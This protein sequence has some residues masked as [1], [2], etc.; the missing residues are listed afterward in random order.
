[1]QRRN[2]TV[3]ISV[4]ILCLAIVSTLVIYLRLGR[5]SPGE[6]RSKLQ[7]GWA[8]ESFAYITS[9]QLVLMDGNRTIA[10]VARFF[11]MFNS[12]EDKVV[13]TN[14]GSYVAFLEDVTAID[15]NPAT[16]KLITVNAHTGAVRRLSCPRCYD[17][18]PVGNNSVL[19]AAAARDSGNNPVFTEFDLSSGGTATHLKFGGIT[20]NGA[21][22]GQFLASTQNLVLFSHGGYADGVYAQYLTLINLDNHAHSNLGYF[23]SNGYELE[24]TS[25]ISG[26]SPSFAVAFRPNPGECVADFPI[27]VFRPMGS[28]RRT[29]MSNAEPPSGTQSVNEGLQV[30]DLWWG[31]D[32]HF[33]ATIESWRCDNSKRSESDKEIPVNAS[34]PWRL[35]GNSWVRN[36][37]QHATMVRQLPGN[38]SITLVIPDCIGPSARRDTIRYCDTGKLYREQRGKAT[39]IANGVI[40]LSS[41]SPR[42][43]PS[44]VPTLGQLAGDFASGKGFGEVKPMEIFNGGDP[45]GL[46]RHIEWESWGGSHATGTGI[47]EWIGPNQTVVSG[48]E[49]PATVVAFDLGKCDG[50]LMYR[51]V[52][53]Y[54]PQHGQSFNPHQYEN[55]CTGAYAPSQ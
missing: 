37:T 2:R 47:A 34:A 48:K 4:I 9:R 31:P 50:Q 8:D 33:H 53:W 7:A 55:I 16:E 42:V 52:E 14:D 22:T 3:L 18:T 5:G 40:S 39:L 32:G 20:F 12:D 30:N 49:E 29:D 17:L 19:T 28:A 46:V 21:Y 6:S 15:E 51:A 41:P 24:A 36:G 23:P 1:M 25:N 11:P 44:P 13:W 10:R 45:T 38:G 26:V 43:T 54:F 27:Y 35:D